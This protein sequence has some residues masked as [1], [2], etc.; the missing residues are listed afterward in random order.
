M[1]IP[2]LSAMTF[3]TTPSLDLR[4]IRESDAE[5]LAAMYDDGRVARAA[6]FGYVVPQSRAQ[7]AKFL[8]AQ[9]KALMHVVIETKGAGEGEEGDFVGHLCVIPSGQRP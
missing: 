5:K 3:A 9:D 4:A 6:N 1:H 8:E 2:I 7:F